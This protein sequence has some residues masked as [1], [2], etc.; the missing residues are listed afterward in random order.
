M[1]ASAATSLVLTTPPPLTA[2]LVI[3][4]GSG[5]RR[6]KV[7]NLDLLDFDLSTGAI[8]VR[9]GKGGKDRMVYLPEEAIGVVEEWI[10]IRGRAA[11]SLLCKVNKT[12]RVVLQ[13]LM[14]Q[15]LL[16]LLQKR[17]KRAENASFSLHDF[18]RTFAGNL[19]DA[20]VDIV[21]VQKLMGHSSP[22]TT[23]RYCRI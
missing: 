10:G 11:G 9:S 5:L 1:L 8:L 17:A 14:P 23:S 19:L 15:A 3:L 16:Y 6:R 4:R 13:R 21:T 2:M 22:D 20:G 12:G 18:R 7:V